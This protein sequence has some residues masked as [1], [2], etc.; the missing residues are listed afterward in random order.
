MLRPD[1]AA[2]QAYPRSELPVVKQ[3]EPGSDHPGFRAA[4]LSLNPLL[5]SGEL[6]LYD[7]SLLPSAPA[8]SRVGGPESDLPC[9]AE[10]RLFL[11]ST[12]ILCHWSESMVWG[13]LSFSFHGYVLDAR[14]TS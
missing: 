7:R 4:F 10:Q 3:A 8:S 6:V 1:L 12:T 13:P 9:S 14:G 5:S 2:I 11:W